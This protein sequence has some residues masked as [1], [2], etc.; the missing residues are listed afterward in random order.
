MKSTFLKGLVMALIAF[1]GQTIAT[2]GLPHNGLEWLVLG[3]SIL[4]AGFGYLAAADYIPETAQ[5]WNINIKDLVKATFSAL[6][7]ATTGIITALFAGV[8]IDWSVVGYGILN[9]IIGGTAKSF[10]TQ[11]K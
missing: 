11:P 7:M 2:Q 5:L 6:A 1:I 4:G 10:L 9:M 3:V 8:H